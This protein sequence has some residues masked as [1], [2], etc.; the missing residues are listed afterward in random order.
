MNDFEFIE[1]K[2]KFRLRE[3]NLLRRDD[4]KR[5]Q[6]IFEQD[7]TE[8]YDTMNGMPQFVQSA[9]KTMLK[10]ANKQKNVTFEERID[11]VA[12]ECCPTFKGRPF[13]SVIMGAQLTKFSMSRTGSGD[14]P[15]ILLSFT[16]IFG[17]RK[18][19]HDWAFDHKKADFWADFEPQQAEI[20][21][22][23]EV[24]NGEPAA[25]ADGKEAAP[26]RGLTLAKP[27]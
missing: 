9:Y 13:F 7:L 16:A 4:E 10:S 6:F 27:N 18:E 11:N 1:G 2:K 20:F 26:K 23:S 19:I 12:I 25:A 15:R 21:T 14:E 5:Q 24:P 17:A 8:G 3:Y 22:A